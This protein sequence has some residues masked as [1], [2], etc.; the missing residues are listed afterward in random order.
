MT[1]TLLISPV[2]LLLIFYIEEKETRVPLPSALEAWRRRWWNTGQAI[3][4]DHLR[5]QPAGAGHIWSLPVKQT[6]R[7]SVAAAP[8]RLFLCVWC[9]LLARWR[10]STW[11][12]IICI[13]LFVTT[14]NTR[15]MFLIS[16]SAV[17]PLLFLSPISFIAYGVYSIHSISLYYENFYAK[18]L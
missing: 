14:T 11:F 16:T 6:A 5:A 7:A 4:S 15:P 17:S 9:V 1:R 10:T 2:T 3:V 12:R 8:S 13:I 18:G